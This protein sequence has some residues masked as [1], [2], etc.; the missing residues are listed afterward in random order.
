[1]L[2]RRSL[3]LELTSLDPEIE[4]TARKNHKTLAK[5]GPSVE[6]EDQHENVD[7]TRSLR[8]LFALVATNSHLCIVLPP[9][10][11]TQVDLKPHV[12]QLLSFHG[13]EMENPYSHVKK[14]KDIS[15]PSSF[16]IFLKSLS[17]LNYSLS[18]F[19]IEPRHGWIVT[20]TDP[21]HHGKSC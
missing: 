1:M 17:I 2:G 19:T 14:F 4:R 6:M 12:I 21:S 13:L 8:E 10:I 9:T 7:L 11:A 15:P 16:R 18:P 20:C 3:N 5:L